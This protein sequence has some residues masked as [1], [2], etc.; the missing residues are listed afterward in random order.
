[1]D[2]NNQNYP[3]RQRRVGRAIKKEVINR[4][5]DRQEHSHSH[6]ENSLKRKVDLNYEV[7]A[8]KRKS[9]KQSIPFVLVDQSNK[10]LRNL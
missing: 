4:K 10:Q 8:I 5:V 6:S 9:G 3:S 7:P 2:N 1:M